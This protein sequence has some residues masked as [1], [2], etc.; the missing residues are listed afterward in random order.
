[1]K[2]L[3]IVE[4]QNLQLELMK[5][6]HV[7]MEDNH[8]KYYLIAGSALGASRHN[9]FIPWDDDIDIGLFRDEYEKFI[10]ISSAF[11]KNYDVVNYKNA[12]NCDYSL[13][14]IYFPDTYIENPIIEG[15]KLDKRLYFDIFPLDNI[16]DDEHE[17]KIY[18]QQVLKKKAVI[19]RMDVKNNGNSKSALAIKKAISLVLSPFRNA[20]IASFDK[21]SQKYRSDS[22]RCV[23]S[24]SSQYS[25]KKQVIPKVVYGE[26]TLHVF[27]RE[28]FYVPEQLDVYL[29]TLYGANY[30]EVPPIENRRKGHNI[31][32]TNEV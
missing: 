27:E 10:R 24:L 18:E 30:S 17:L 7:F 29:T 16:P 5:K 31:Y 25:F 13:T 1:M 23:C 32:R 20:I 19:Q 14:R 15:T 11:D 4:V 6:L 28:R 8:I 21:L 22:T 12:S 3:D 26:P 9:G 2:L